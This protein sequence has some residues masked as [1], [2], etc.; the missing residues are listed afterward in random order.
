MKGYYQINIRRASNGAKRTLNFHNHILP[1]FYDILMAKTVADNK[2]S[3]I[4]T[5][6][7]GDGVGTH[8]DT[9]STFN[10]EIV[11]ERTYS[12]YYPPT[13]LNPLYKETEFHHTFE[14]KTIL[15]QQMR[16]GEVGVGT[17]IDGQFVLASMVHIQDANGDPNSIVLFPGDELSVVWN[18]IIA[19]PVAVLYKATDQQPEMISSSLYSYSNSISHE[20]DYEMLAAYPNWHVMGIKRILNLV[21]ERNALLTKSRW[22]WSIYNSTDRVYVEVPNPTKEQLLVTGI[23]L[24][25]DHLDPAYEATKTF[26]VPHLLGPMRVFWAR[27]EYGDIIPARVN[28]RM[29]IQDLYASW[30]SSFRTPDSKIR[31]PRHVDFLDVNWHLDTETP[32]VGGT[33]YISIKSIKHVLVTIYQ[34]NRVL[35]R[36]MTNEF[37]HLKVTH[38]NLA[39]GDEISV[40][41]HVQGHQLVRT[42]TLTQ[43]TEEA[44]NVIRYSHYEVSPRAYGET[45]RRA[46]FVVRASR[47]NKRFVANMTV[48]QVPAAEGATR[49]TP[50]IETTGG[51]GDMVRMLNIDGDIIAGDE[52]TITLRDSISN[53]VVQTFK[54]TIQNTAMG[55]QFHNQKTAPRDTISLKVKMLPL[56]Q[57]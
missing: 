43:P 32:R 21:L 31:E 2:N 13:N 7:F 33:P 23:E 37:G 54:H 56:P 10:G 45:S 40:R 9:A 28:V 25:V 50:R 44:T 16:I 30:V 20:I 29:I 52:F 48:K 39:M 47:I 36:D 18:L 34:N 55:T 42:F 1:G 24:N 12:N 8:P 53:A 4:D 15:T 6:V 57:E 14:F 46:V 51:Y 22:Y 35:I 27:Q 3:V 38:A 26:F 49:G 41:V 5:L 17:R 19:R 11:F